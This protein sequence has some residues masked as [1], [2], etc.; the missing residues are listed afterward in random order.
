MQVISEVE[1]ANTGLTVVRVY[2][3]NTPNVGLEWQGSLHYDDDDTPLVG[4]SNMNSLVPGVIGI[5]EGYKGNNL[6]AIVR[7]VFS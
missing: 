4:T 7:V 5:P 1:G 2:F 3:I 6:C